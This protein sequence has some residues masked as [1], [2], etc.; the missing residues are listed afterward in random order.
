[1]LNLNHCE[2]IRKQIVE[3]LNLRFKN[4]L[5]I[6]SDTGK[7]HALATISHPKFKASSFSGEKQAMLIDI[8]CTQTRL[9]MEHNLS[10]PANETPNIGSD[11]KQ[12]DIFE[13]FSVNS[14]SLD[15]EDE[16]TETIRFLKTKKSDLSIL[17]EFPAIK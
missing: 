10:T 5:N 7:I 1:M 12:N 13:L 15:R 4:V 9:N 3:S 8:F 6:K 16:D 17:N 11:S 14:E 2:L